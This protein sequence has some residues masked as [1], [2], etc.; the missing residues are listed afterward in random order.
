M[1]H[2]PRVWYT[3]LVTPLEA[4]C[5][6]ADDFGDDEGFFPGAESLCMPS[7]F[8]MRLRTRSP[9]CKGGLFN[10]A[11]VA[12]TK[13]LVV[14]G[15]SHDSGHSLLFKAVEVDMTSLFDFSLLVE[16]NART[17]KGDVGG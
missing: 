17:S 15:L 1:L 13:L 6:W 16:L 14:T 10:V 8:W 2:V 7:V 9:T 4:I 3:L 5:G 12:P 11:I